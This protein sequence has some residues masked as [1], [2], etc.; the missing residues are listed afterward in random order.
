MTSNL[1]QLAKLKINTDCCIANTE[2]SQLGWVHF[3]NKRQ[4]ASCKLRDWMHELKLTKFLLL[5]GPPHPPK[6]N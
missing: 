4:V 1:K 5:T 6:F 3:G 2:D